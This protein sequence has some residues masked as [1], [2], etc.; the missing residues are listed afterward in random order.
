MIRGATIHA[1]GKIW[2]PDHFQ[3][4]ACVRF[5][6]TMPSTTTTFTDLSNFHL[7]QM[8]APEFTNVADA[9]YPFLVG[10]SLSN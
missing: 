8:A 4:S 5:F 3:A 1:V 6:P 10:P 9:Q 7:G 2:S